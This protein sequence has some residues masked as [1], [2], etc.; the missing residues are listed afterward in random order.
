MLWWIVWYNLPDW[1]TD[2]AKEKLTTR[3]KQCNATRRKRAVRK[4]Y[5]AT[6]RKL[7]LLAAVG[8]TLGVTA[9]GWWYWHSGRLGHAVTGVADAFWNR[10]ADMGF[11][12]KDIYLE[13]RKYTSRQAVDEALEVK[14][15][16]AIFGL[17]LQEIRQRL[18]AVPRVKY[19]E[20]AR[21]LPDQLHVRLVEREPV[22]VW[23][24][25]GKL[26]LIDPDGVV[27]EYAE[28]KNY[29]NLLLVVG[30]DAPTHTRELL[31][32]LALE[33]ELY[34]QIS[35]AVRVGERRWNINFKN[36]VELKLPEQAADMAWKQFAEMDRNHHMLSRPIIYV[37]MRLQDR[38]FIK[39]QPEQKAAD[40]K[41]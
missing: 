41:A 33:P 21:V 15:G 35:S 28:I 25:N 31:N 18:E 11:K 40:K 17:S 12:V 24:N 29:P 16:D 37:D 8:L 7:A 10:T 1:E 36:G 9:G 4:W 14:P 5:N 13:G 30:E 34:K 6:T 23:Q 19:A 22:A 39:Q 27:M 26:S 2:V 38:V 3:Q 32:T 20:V